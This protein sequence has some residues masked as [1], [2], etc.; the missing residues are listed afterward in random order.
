MRQYRTKETAGFLKGE[1]VIN[2]QRESHCQLY[3][4]DGI[5]V[6]RINRITNMCVHE[7]QRGDDPRG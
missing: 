5:D 2:T 3:W 6:K 7:K 4:V 1:G